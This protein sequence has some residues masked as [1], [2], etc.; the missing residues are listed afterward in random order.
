TTC[1]FG[2]GGGGFLVGQQPGVSK[3]NSF[4][5]N[6]NNLWGKKVEVNGS[7]F[8]NSRN[9]SNLETLSRETFLNGDSSQFLDQS[10]VSAS[11]NYNHRANMRITYNID[12]NNTIIITPSVSFQRYSSF[13]DI[14]GLNFY[15]SNDPISI[16]ENRSNSTRD[17][18]NFNNNILYRHSFAKRGRT[19]SANLSTRV[20]N[21]EGQ[22][23]TDAFTTYYKGN[24]NLDDSLQQFSDQNTKG[25]TLS[26][27]LNYSEPIGKSGIIQFSYNPS[28]TLNKSNQETYMYDGNSGKYSEFD[29]SLSNVFENTYVTQRGGISY[30]LGD[31]NKN[32]SLGFDYQAAELNS[33]QVFPY[34]TTVK[35]TFSNILPNA[36]VRFNFS[37]QSNIRIFYRAS[38]NPPSVN[39]LQEVINNTNPLMIS[40]GNPQLKQ[41]YGHRLGARYQFTNT[42][43]GRAF[44]KYIRVNYQ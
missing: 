39:Q 19:L 25:L 20:N 29:T 41:Q 17:A 24:I 12:S 11:T 6:Y 9:L 33:D 34:V 22:T 4:G 1:S 21:N 26:A 36:M 13:S 14:S 2:G 8:F 44:C 5:L 27:N 7:Y 43:R 31:Q 37:K 28:Y 30:R 18:L 16:I 42:K 38:T 15:E 32:I 10:T 3:T 23:Y 35:R 40:T